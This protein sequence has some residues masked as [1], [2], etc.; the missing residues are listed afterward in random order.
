VVVSAAGQARQ[1]AWQKEGLV[2][3]F[4]DQ[5]A[6]LRPLLAERPAARM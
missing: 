4:L 6:V 1:P 3:E 2:G 5:R